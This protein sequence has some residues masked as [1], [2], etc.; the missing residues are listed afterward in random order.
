[1]GRNSESAP[2]ETAKDVLAYLRF[3]GYELTVEQLARLHRQRLI[4]R[5]FH[6]SGGIR[7]PRKT[8]PAGTAERMLRI[9]QLEASSKK[10]DELAWRLWWEGSRVEP[11][12]VRDYLVKMSNR[13][14]DRL[15]EIR[16]SNSSSTTDD[17]VTSDRDVLD[18]VFFQHLTLVPS[19]AAERQRLEKG[20]KVYV[21]FAAILT[22]LLSGDFS[23]LAPPEQGLFE[24]VMKSPFGE[25]L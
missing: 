4:K 12:L 8:Y 19:T 25:Q 16:G 21:E 15:G 14:D 17:E 20:S 18:E 6:D 2:R 13:W 1:M 11:D 9:A 23:I 3:A 24:R 10:L 7:D 5:K 22:D